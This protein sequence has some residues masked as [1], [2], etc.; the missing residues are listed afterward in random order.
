M[1]EDLRVIGIFRHV[2]QF[3]VS[4]P[5]LFWEKNPKQI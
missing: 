3:I 5:V 4:L 1:V 2:Q